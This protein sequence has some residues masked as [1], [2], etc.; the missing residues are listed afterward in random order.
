MYELQLRIFSVKL[1]RDIR[2]LSTFST[3]VAS[4]S[5]AMCSG[6]M[7]LM[8]QESVRYANERQQ[9]GKSISSFGAIKAKLAEQAIRTWVGE[10]MV[11]R[12][13]RDD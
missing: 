5:G 8:V 4:N 9:F 12:T 6:G 11:Y 7:K 1:A 3:L 13:T 10:S 2:L